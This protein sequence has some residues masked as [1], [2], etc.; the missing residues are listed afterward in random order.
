MQYVSKLTR[1]VLTYAELLLDIERHLETKK[2]DKTL[3]WRKIRVLFKSGWDKTL[4]ARLAR[5]SL[6]PLW[7]LYTKTELHRSFN[8]NSTVAEKNDSLRLL[9]LAANYEHE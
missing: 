1:N 7:D 5:T 3:F 4:K 9:W 2:D 6:I 8:P